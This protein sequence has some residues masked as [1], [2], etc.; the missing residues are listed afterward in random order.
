MTRMPFLD[1]I[2]EESVAERTSIF[3]AAVLSGIAN[4]G[5]LAI[6]NAGVA[7]AHL[8]FDWKLLALFVASMGIYVWGLKY[9]FNH[10]AGMLERIISRRTI[11]ITHKI[12]DTELAILET[13]GKATIYNRLVQETEALSQAQ[14]PL[15]NMVQATVVLTFA[16][17]YICI[18]SPIAFAL[19]LI[20]NSATV[21]FYMSR[22]KETTR[23]LKQ[24]TSQSVR[25]I[26][27]VNQL[28]GGF[29]QLKM[30]HRLGEGLLEDIDSASKAARN[31]RV[32]YANLQNGNKILAGSV[33][34]M[35]LGCIVFVLPQFLSGAS[36]LVSEMVASI[37]FIFGPLS[38]IVG[39]MP[40]LKRVNH[41]AANLEALE[42]D[43][44]K[45]K[46]PI[47]TLTG[48]AESP[49]N[50]FQELELQQVEF[51]YRD[52]DEQELFSVG[53]LNLNIERGEIMFVIGGNGS[54]KSTFLKLLT[55]LYE[56]DMGDVLV[57]G[58]PVMRAELQHYRELFSVIF[59]DF[60]LFDKLYG[61]DPVSRETVLELLRQMEIENKV[62]YDGKQFNHLNLSTG[63]RKRVA[64]T[65]ALL[66][67]RP[68]FV[69][70]EWAADQD[71]EFRKYFYQELLPQLRAQGKT[72]IAVTHDDHYFH[73]ADRI[74][75]MDCGKVEYIDRGD[76][77]T[78]TLTKTL[79]PPELMATI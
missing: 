48:D 46:L 70:D 61:L 23:C 43:L 32:R 7:S 44:D 13:I 8:G 16:S 1:L 21:A 73:I 58:Q 34:F 40:V 29:K 79:T 3:C 4:A 75:K 14:R 66:E 24:A 33:S 60:H 20:V 50:G 28:L 51:A 76:D 74:V 65:V 12:K 38:T 64:M 25:L 6:V 2:R 57:D 27:L 39:G 26:D 63:Q 53:P 22:D 55:G 18:L 42:D 41:A 9:A 59:G 72:V 31:D 78:N 36:L 10:G 5:L 67:N 15:L 77:I 54:G 56:P 45:N 30:R 49:M 47:L 17:V 11:R 71:P 37:L 19:I 35:A 52:K 62:G 68:I 69:F